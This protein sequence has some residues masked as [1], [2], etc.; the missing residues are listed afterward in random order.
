MLARYRDG[1]L[2]ERETGRV[3]AA[4][5][6]S[7]ED[8]AALERLSRVGDMVRLMSEEGLST[9]SFEGFERRVMNGIAG[10]ARPGLGE[11]LGVWI[12]E[13]LE[14]RKA[15]WIP[16]A[17]L[18]GAAAAILLVLPL[19]TGSPEVPPPA[20]GTGSGIW[21]ATAGQAAVPGGSE[22]VILSRGQTA[23]MEY[24]VINDRGESIGVAWIND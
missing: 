7:P 16:A 20:M 5:A 22:V 24:E 15:I 11:R 23:G 18:S 21:A 2:S 13:F 1:E 8:A 6:V 19:V 12:G 9:V 10:T 3:E 17:S 14:H 4:L